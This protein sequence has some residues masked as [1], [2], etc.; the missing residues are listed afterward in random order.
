MTPLHAVDLV[1]ASTSR[2]RHELLSRLTSTFRCVAPDVDEQA[3]AGETPAL[4]A[5]RLAEAKAR[6]VGAREAGAL[7]IGSDQVAALDGRV[8]GKPGSAG[9]AIEQLRACA[10]RELHFHTALCLLDTRTQPQRAY[11]AID[12]TR[13]RFRALEDAEISRYVEREQPLDCAGSFKAER[14]G[15]GLFDAIDSADPTALIGLPLIALCRLLREARVAV[16]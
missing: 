4:L 9:K 13:V 2:Y 11:A 7:V 15:I 1:L 3:R 16:I 14:L 6:A 10:G 8:F 12:T 5:T